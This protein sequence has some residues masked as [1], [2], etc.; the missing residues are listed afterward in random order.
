MIKNVAVTEPPSHATIVPSRSVA[1]FYRATDGSRRIARLAAAAAITHARKD[2]NRRTNA[3][4]ARVQVLDRVGFSVT[5]KQAKQLVN[6]ANGDGS[7]SEDGLTFA[8]LQHFVRLEEK[9]FEQSKTARAQRDLCARYCPSAGVRK[10]YAK[11]SW[12]AAT[13]VTHRAF[14]PFICVRRA[15][16]G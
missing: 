11:L 5:P 1:R 12:A 2:D 3:R 8:Q 7:T 9:L 14:D 10:V 13:I 16:C 4:R 15:L 6:E